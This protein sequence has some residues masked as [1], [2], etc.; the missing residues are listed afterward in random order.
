MTEPL[1]PAC[2]A[3]DR[4]LLGTALGSYRLSALLYCEQW[5]MTYLDALREARQPLLPPPTLP[6][7]PVLARACLRC[8]E[9][10]NRGVNLVLQSRVRQ[11]V[12]VNT[13]HAVRSPQELK[14]GG[15]HADRGVDRPPRKPTAE[16]A[17]SFECVSL[18]RSVPKHTV[19]FQTE[20]GVGALFRCHFLK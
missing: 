17:K 10:S 7:L 15:T 2:G 1:C 4:H 8:L 18:R 3:S 19:P 11:V 13:P 20:R 6:S 5:P 16:E 14:W 9:H 12:C